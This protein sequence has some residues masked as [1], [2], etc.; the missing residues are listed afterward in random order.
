M[1]HVSGKEIKH[2]E[3]NKVIYKDDKDGSV[4]ENVLLYGVSISYYPS[5]IVGLMVQFLCII[6]LKTTFWMYAFCI[7]YF[8]GFTLQLIIL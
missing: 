6:Y 2:S 5:F 7:F 1:K 4:L 8:L 3:V